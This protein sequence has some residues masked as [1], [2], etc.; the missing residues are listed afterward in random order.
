MLNSNQNLTDKSLEQKQKEI[1][2]LFPFVSQKPTEKNKS[3][4][5][6]GKNQ[7]NTGS[8]IQWSGYNP[9]N[10]P[11]KEITLLDI[12]NN[13]IGGKELTKILAKK[14]KKQCVLLCTS[15]Y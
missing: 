12:E 13:N 3:K 4:T 14:E 7:L 9:E 6:Q 1:K 10:S 2:K 15:I 11:K 8:D 5:Q